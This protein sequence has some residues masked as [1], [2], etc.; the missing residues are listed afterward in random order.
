[1]NVLVTTVG[2]RAKMKEYYIKN[3]VHILQKVK[4]YR[5]RKKTDPIWMKQKRERQRLYDIKNRQRVRELQKIYYGKLRLKILIYYGG[6][7]PICKCGFSDIRALTIDHING[8][9][10]KHRKQ[11]HM[12]FYQWIKKNNFPEGFQVLCMNCQFIKERM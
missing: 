8:G 3:K 12:M 1:M 4:E 7:P 2:Q 11:M 10:C 5:E 6:D 9:G